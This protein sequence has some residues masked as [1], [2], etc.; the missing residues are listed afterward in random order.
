MKLWFIKGSDL[1]CFLGEREHRIIEESSSIKTVRKGESLISD[2]EGVGTVYMLNTGAAKITKETRRDLEIVT[3]VLPS[4]SLF[5]EASPTESCEKNEAVTALEDCTL[6]MIDIKEF[7]ALFESLP[8]FSALRRAMAEFSD[9]KLE[10]KL[11]QL[12]YCTVEKRLATL[13]LRLLDD[14]G[15][16]AVDG[17]LLNLRLTHQDIAD[18]I[19]STRETTTVRLNTFRQAGLIDYM[20]KHIVIKSSKGLKTIA[21][22]ECSSNSAN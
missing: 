20:D 15:R 8:G 22:Q 1:A 12:L 5:G 4:R 2:E 21:A 19:A 18:M 7:N 3:E 11:F 13:L 9:V 6:C 10:K 16:P 17:Y 14:F